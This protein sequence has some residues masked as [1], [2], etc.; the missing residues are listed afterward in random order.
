MTAFPDH[1]TDPKTGLLVDKDSKHLIGIEQKPVKV[2]PSSEFPK[3]VVPHDSL[4]VRDGSHV[5]VPF[6]PEFHVD[7][8]GKVTVLVKDAEEEDRAT[9]QTLTVVEGHDPSEAI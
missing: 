9:S 8:D 2:E 4:V 5:S 6:Y 3:W 7:R 1:E